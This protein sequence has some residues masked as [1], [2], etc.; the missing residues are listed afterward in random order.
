[1][2]AIS[3][4]YPTTIVREIEPRPYCPCSK[5]RSLATLGSIPTEDLE[6]LIEDGKDLELV[7]DFCRSKYI[8]TPDEIRE[9]LNERLK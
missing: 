3:G 8:V 5:V 7:C 4:E 1:M 6:E 2:Q 9:I